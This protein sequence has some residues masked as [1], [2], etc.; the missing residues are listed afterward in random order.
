MLII[1][2]IFQ[3][4]SFKYSAIFHPTAQLQSPKVIPLPK[5]HGNPSDQLM[6]KFY[7]RTCESSTTIKINQTRSY[8]HPF[9][10]Y[11]YEHFRYIFQGFVECLWP[12]RF[13]PFAH[14][15]A[16]PSA[17]SDPYRVI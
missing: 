2:F 5:M 13:G 16:A 14:S 8:R 4:I 15:V 7:G 1:Y 11:K 9:E 10:Y 3:T 6:I 17:Y 12:F